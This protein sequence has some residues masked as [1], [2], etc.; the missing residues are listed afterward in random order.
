MKSE[1][2]LTVQSRL[3]IAHSASVH[4]RHINFCPLDGIWILPQEIN[5]LLLCLC[6]WEIFKDGIR[7]H[8]CLFTQDKRIICIQILFSGDNLILVKAFGCGKKS[9][10]ESDSS[11]CFGMRT[12]GFPVFRLIPSSRNNLNTGNPFVRIPKQ[13]LESDSDND[14]LPQPNA[15]TKIRSSPENKIWIQII[16]LSWVNKKLWILIPSLNIS[17]CHKH[18]DNLFISRGSIRIPSGG[19]KLICLRCGGA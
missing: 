7:I 8:N 18:S 16:L 4:L 10:S 12:K 15:L 14:F 5:R 6:Q 17:H 3:A 13:L 19:Q 2:L 9:L 1:K 11:K